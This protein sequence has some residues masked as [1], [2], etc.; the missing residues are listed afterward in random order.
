MCMHLRHLQVTG[1]MHAYGILAFIFT[2]FLQESAIPSLV[3]QDHGSYLGHNVSMPLWQSTIGAVIAILLLTYT[4]ECI[5]VL[6][7]NPIF[8]RRHSKAVQQSC[9]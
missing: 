7:S 2:R 8:Y 9:R 6:F 1:A 4:A 5:T 3:L